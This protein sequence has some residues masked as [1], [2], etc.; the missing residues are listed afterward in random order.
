M[1]L[2]KTGAAGTGQPPPH[3][4][5]SNRF[6]VSGI[7]PDRTG[8]V[9]FRLTLPGPGSVDVLETA[10]KN[11]FATVALLQPAT[12]RF[13]FA[14][15]HIRASRSGTLHVVVNPNARGALVL[16]HH[17]YRVTLR[18]WVTSHQPGVA[19]AALAFTGSGFQLVSTPTRTATARPEQPAERRT[20]SN[21]VAFAVPVLNRLDVRSIAGPS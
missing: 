1:F 19:L 15:A 5:P 4:P 9:R 17:R 3:R 18:L 21:K 11:N 13:V 16:F 20:F 2:F 6:T 7:T 12:R 14:R 8:A 10:W